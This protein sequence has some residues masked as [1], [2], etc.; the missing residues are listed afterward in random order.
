MVLLLSQ[1][2]KGDN[3]LGKSVLKNVRLPT[4]DI[5]LLMLQVWGFFCLTIEWYLLLLCG[6]LIASSSTMSLKVC[7]KSVFCSVTALFPN[8]PPHA[9][10]WRHLALCIMNYHHFFHSAHIKLLCKSFPVGSWTSLYAGIT[11]CRTICIVQD[12]KEH[13]FGLVWFRWDVNSHSTC[14]TL[15][16][17]FLPWV[18]LEYQQLFRQID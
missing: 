6:C 3:A 11:P 1:W 9:A 13:R 14:E 2:V 17:L 7:V 16:I 12:I 18:D 15:S 5:S 10:K 8:V 4:G